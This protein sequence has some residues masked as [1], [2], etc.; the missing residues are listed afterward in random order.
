MTSPNDRFRGALVGLAVGDAVGTSVEFLRRGEF[1]PVTDMVGGGA[2]N[3]QPGEW[4][5]DTSLALCL[6]DSLINANGMD[7]TDQLERYVRWYKHGYMSSNGYCFDIG[8]TTRKALHDFTE[9][10]TE[11][12]WY[13]DYSLGNGSIMRLAPVPMFFWPNYE[14]AVFN[15][16][17][18][19]RTTHSAPECIEACR[20]LGSIIHNALDGMNKMQ[21]LLN[22]NG[23]K[24]VNESIQ[25]ISECSYDGKPETIIKGSGYVIQSL[26]AALWCFLNTDNFRDAVLKATNLGDDADTTAAI[27]GQVAGAYYGIEGIPEEWVKKIAKLDLIEALADNLRD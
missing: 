20:L 16:G 15:S 21:M 12:A 25:D 1:T 7:A 27:C 10:G 17:L 4:T 3:L 26:E 11:V 19:S 2:F 23:Q 13:D 14:L 8:G 18:S 9:M 24:F 5:D 22:H 6:A